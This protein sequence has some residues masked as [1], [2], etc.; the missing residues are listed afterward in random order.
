[1]FPLSACVCPIKGVFGALPLKKCDKGDAINFLSPT[2]RQVSL[3]TYWSNHFL[4]LLKNSQAKKRKSERAWMHALKNV[5][6]V[7]SKLAHQSGSQHALQAILALAHVFYSVDYPWGKE[8]LRVVYF[9]GEILI[10]H[11]LFWVTAVQYFS[12]WYNGCAVFLCY[13]FPAKVIFCIV[14]WSCMQLQRWSGLVSSASYFRPNFWSEDRT[15]GSW[16]LLSVV[17]F[18]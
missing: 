17:L 8:R 3:A 18:P 7:P 11:G 13:R 6:H 9:S 1:M 14:L 10:Y 4:F 15:V 12:I 2:Q 5:T 16:R